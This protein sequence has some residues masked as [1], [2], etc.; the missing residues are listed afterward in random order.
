MMYKQVE[1]YMNF[2]AIDLINISLSKIK[3]PKHKKKSW[4]ENMR[5][6]EPSKEMPRLSNHNP[7]GLNHFHS[8][9]DSDKN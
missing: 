2:F 3:M 6:V 4:D 8:D 5:F 9:L 1:T 7:K